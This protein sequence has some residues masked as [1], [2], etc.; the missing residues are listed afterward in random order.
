MTHVLA[1]ALRT[2]VA[3]PCASEPSASKS[4]CPWAAGGCG[5]PR[6]RFDEPALES[7]FGRYAAPEALRGEAVGCECDL[8]SL[9]VILYILVCG[10]P[11]FFQEDI[12]ELVQ[13]IQ[14][15]EYDYPSPD[16]DGVSDGARRLVDAWLQLEPARRAPADDMRA[17][18]S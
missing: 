12:P 4:I 1:W 5:I 17:R 8:W 6:P 11:P 13:A 7:R 3:L 18:Q 15:G 2:R 14:A 10:F 9:G 16:C